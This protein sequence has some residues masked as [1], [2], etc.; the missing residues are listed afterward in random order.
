[1]KTKEL[2]KDMHIVTDIAEE[3]YKSVGEILKVASSM[4]D[5]ANDLSNK[6]NSFKS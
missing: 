1:M 2:V 3:N 5:Q 6:L 4:L